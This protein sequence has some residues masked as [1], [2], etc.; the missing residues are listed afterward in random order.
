[1]RLIQFNIYSAYLYVKLH[2]LYHN[3]LGQNWYCNSD[4]R[5]SNTGVTGGGKVRGARW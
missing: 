5:N 2:Y 4:S 3:G 1:M